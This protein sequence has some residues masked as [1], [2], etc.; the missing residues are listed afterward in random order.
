MLQGI[1][2]AICLQT[3]HPEKMNEVV[4][5]NLFCRNEF[6]SGWVGSSMF[7]SFVL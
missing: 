6:L 2:T 5:W 1:G 4:D 3:S 7:L